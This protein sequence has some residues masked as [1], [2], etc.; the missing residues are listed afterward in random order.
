MYPAAAPG[1]LLIYVCT[2]LPGVIGEVDWI[3]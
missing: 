3:E 1:D 2:S